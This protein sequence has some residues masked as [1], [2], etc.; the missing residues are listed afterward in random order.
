M[1]A[2]DFAAA[3]RYIAAL[4]PDQQV[5]IQGLLLNA[6]QLSSV[7]QQLTDKLTDKDKQLTDKDRQL[8]YLKVDKDKQLERLEK[9]KSQQLAGMDM[10]ATSKDQ[11]IDYQ[12][13]QIA[14]LEAKLLKTQGMHAALTS[15][16][17]VLEVY[18]GLLFAG[19]TMTFGLGQI[20]KECI[21][22]Q[23]SKPVL[24]AEASKKLGL[25]EGRQV[26][27]TNP[28]VSRVSKGFEEVGLGSGGG[29]RAVPKTPPPPP[30]TFTLPETLA[31]TSKLVLGF[32][33]V[34]SGLVYFSPF[35]PTTRE[36]LRLAWQWKE[37]SPFED[38]YETMAWQ[39]CFG[40]MGLLSGFQASRIVLEKS[41]A[42]T[43]SAFL[44]P[45][46]IPFMVLCG[47][48]GAKLTISL[49]SPATNFVLLVGRLVEFSVGGLMVDVGAQQLHDL[50]WGHLV[51]KAKQSEK[52]KEF[53][54]S[55][56][57]LRDLSRVS[58]SLE[59]LETI[60][61]YGHKLLLVKELGKLRMQEKVIT[62]T[63][64]KM[65][66]KS[67]AKMLS[68][69]RQRKGHIKQ[70]CQQ[71]HGFKI[72]R[73][74]E[75]IQTNAADKLNGLREEQLNLVLGPNPK[76]S[77]LKRLDAEKARLKREAR[78]ALGVKLSRYAKP[79]AKWKRVWKDVARNN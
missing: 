3:F 43:G 26:P 59:D 52:T 2:E 54:S 70:Q 38:M 64:G 32:G 37:T 58:G 17:P 46:K 33:A 45:F 57:E 15:M 78:L 77:D 66:A 56:D 13:D 73:L 36:G 76:M 25:L 74:F 40:A 1:S 18:V 34:T 75:E 50:D 14:K 68:D 5:I 39:L 30:L 6:V 29:V 12:S 71:V 65:D 61:A 72:A 49:A 4:P 44:L 53:E 23:G 62:E 63:R 67:A 41:L 35:F 60:G 22:Y 27:G 16:R 24:N 21:D 31:N 48:L 19:K 8:A 51:N 69:I 7:K 28:N 42:G 20:A 55:G 9:E 47:M 11:M 10:Y 79:Y